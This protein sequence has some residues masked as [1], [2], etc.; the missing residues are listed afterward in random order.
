MAFDLWFLLAVSLIVML[1]ALS[2]GRLSRKEG[3]ALIAAYVAYTAYTV[4]LF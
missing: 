2:G 1:F 4:G 3:I